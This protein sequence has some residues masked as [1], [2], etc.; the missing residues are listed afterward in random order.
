MLGKLKKSGKSVPVAIFVEVVIPRQSFL[1]SEIVQTL[2]F[3][4]TESILRPL[5]LKVQSYPR[6]HAQSNIHVSRTTSARLHFIKITRELYPKLFDY[7]PGLAELWRF[8]FWSL[9][10]L[11][12]RANEP[13]RVLDRIFLLRKCKNPANK[14]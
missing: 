3:I 9:P 2:E 1:V 11:W 13:L 10:R 14:V 7:P 5:L 8:L 4:V 12:C 6:E